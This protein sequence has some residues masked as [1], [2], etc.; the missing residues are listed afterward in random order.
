MT[1]AVIMRCDTLDCWNETEPDIDAFRD[2]TMPSG[3]NE[4]DGYHYCV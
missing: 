1:L 4:H 2:I 3:W